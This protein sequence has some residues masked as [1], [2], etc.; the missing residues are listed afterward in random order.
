MDKWTSGADYDQW[1]G[2][3]SRL[4][5][6]EFVKWLRLPANL[7]WLDLCCGT[8]VLTEAIVEHSAPSQVTGIDAS[9]QQIAFASTHRS[10]T[11][12]V[13]QT[14]DAMSLPFGQSAFDVVV[15]GLGL[16]YLPEPL[17]A[18]AEM[19]RVVAPSG[20]IAIYVWDY[21]EGARFLREFWEAAAAIDPNALR[22]DQARRF[23]QCTPP[24]LQKIFHDAHLDRV[25]V[26][27]LDITTRFENFD[28]Y[29]QPLLTGQG[30]APSYL[31]TLDPNTRSDIRARLRQS[32]F[33]ADG[34][35]ELPARAWAVRGQSSGANALGSLP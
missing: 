12:V 29:W 17:R 11:N 28:D 9:A 8:G 31:E 13:F 7:R 21:S 15:C 27:P 19:R 35:I 14:S 22:Y 1:M 23:P 16:N 20:V 32:L 34:P 30:S 33:S 2:R 10:G 26:A 18:L 5:A 4:L 25:L 24:A 6:G 3:W